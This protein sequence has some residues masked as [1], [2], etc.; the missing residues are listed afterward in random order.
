MKVIGVIPARFGSTRFEGKPLVGICGKSM[1][2]RVYEQTQKA[3]LIDEVYI[4]AD[5]DRIKNEAESFGAKVIM[6]SKEHTCG[7]DRIAEAIQNIEGE[8]ILNVQGDEPLIEPEAL[9]AVIKPLQ[10]DSN[11]E[12]ATLITPMEDESECHDP[13][14]V[15]VVKDKNDFALYFSRSLI[16]YSREGDM[17]G[18][19]KQIGV[20]A[21]RRGFLLAFSKME[22][23]PYEKVERLEQLR[24][25]ENGCKIKLVETTYNPISVDVPADV[26]KVE[27]IL[28]SGRN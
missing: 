13:N 5:D 26:A 22:P 12:M 8:I 7:T 2:Q 10:E 24:A 27:N 20:Y 23:T 6:T 25:L 9:D 19:F 3:R 11:I 15:K 17:T 21:Y 18:V 14:I 1:I 4:A 16:P 28:K